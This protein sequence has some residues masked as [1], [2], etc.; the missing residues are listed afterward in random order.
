[1]VIALCLL[2]STPIFGTENFLK[3]EYGFTGTNGCV[4]CDQG[5]SEEG[6]Y[7]LGEVIL[8]SGSPYGVIKFD[9]D[10]K[11]VGEAKMVA[12]RTQALFNGGEFLEFTIPFT[13]S[14][15]PHDGTITMSGEGGLEI[16]S[17]GISCFRGL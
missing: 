14:F 13:Y 7:P 9:K 12:V 10:G 17:K 2:V 6:L 5:F 4:N 1:M 16:G 3:G 11:G 8:I 15:N